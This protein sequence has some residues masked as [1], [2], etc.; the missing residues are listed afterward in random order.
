MP[1]VQRDINGN[2]KGTY[3]NSQ[4]GY[5]EEFLPDDNTEV[6]VYL[7]PKPI[8]KQLTLDDV[9]AVLKAS[10]PELSVALDDKLTSKK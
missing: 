7:E 3:A 9:V 6:L 8:P 2:V 4:S 5:A 1:Y 10:S